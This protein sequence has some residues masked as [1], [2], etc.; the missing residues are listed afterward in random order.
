MK[1][2]VIVHSKTGI[3]LKLGNMFAESLRK[4]GH[5]VDVVEL[6]TEPPVNSGTAKNHPT[7]S[8]TNLPDC[9]KYDALLVG[10]PVWAFS[11]SPVIYEAVKGLKDVS[12]K[13]VVPFVSMGFL[14]SPWAESRRSLC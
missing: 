4:K 1:I 12:G 11:A 9:K 13:K 6:K 10:G 8:I 14:T 5:I 3:T 2:A 7:F